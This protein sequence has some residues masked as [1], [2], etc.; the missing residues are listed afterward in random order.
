MEPTRSR[1]WC[2][3]TLLLC[4]PLSATAASYAPMGDADLLGQSATVVLGRV[5]HAGPAPAQELDATLYR[6][7]IDRILKGSPGRRSLELTVPGAHAPEQAGALVIPG[8]P[9][10]VPDERVLLF[11]DT[12]DSGRYRLNQ[13]GLGAFHVRRAGDGTPLALRALEHEPLTRARGLDAFLHW[14][15]QATTGASPTVDYWTDMAPADSAKFNFIGVEASRWFEFDRGLEVRFLAH[16][17]GQAGLSD[18]GVGAFRQGLAA[19]DDD[20]GSNIRYVFGGSTRAGGGLGTPDGVN[21]ILFN[22][23]N[24]EIAGSFD[25]NRGGILALGGFRSSGRG[26]YRNGSFLMIV[27]GDVVVQDG[28]ACQLSRNNGSNAAEVFAHELGHTLGLAHSCG[29]NSLLG[30]IGDCIPLTPVDEAL[31]RART[32]ADGRGARLGADDR[33]AVGSAY[34]N[35]LLPVLRDSPEGLPGANNVNGGDAGADDGGGGGGAA[36]VLTLLGLLAAG[37]WRTRTR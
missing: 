29:D 9:R 30:L 24:G 37:L 17:N 3:R 20:G 25:C 28:A 36:A 21:T 15:L 26:E 14:L 13:F 10:F 2:I 18:G 1:N 16:Q 8:A 27:E 23:P 31:M 11:L 6:I 35:G 32:H 5:A 22:D 34:G 19:W 7:E 12:G 4:I 33:A